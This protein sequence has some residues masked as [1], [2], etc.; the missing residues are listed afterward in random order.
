MTATQHHQPQEQAIA[1]EHDWK[2]DA[3]LFVGALDAD[4]EGIA[5][6]FDLNP[7]FAER[8]EKTARKRAQRKRERE[9][10]EQKEQEE[11]EDMRK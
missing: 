5:K 8:F 11:Q 1:C 6:A 2:D 7:E 3:E 9:L 10:Q 4:E